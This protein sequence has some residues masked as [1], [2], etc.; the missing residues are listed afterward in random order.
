MLSRVDP[1]QTKKLPLK[2]DGCIFFQRTVFGGRGIPPNRTGSAA[3]LKL[4]RGL[5]PREFH[6]YHEV[7]RSYLLG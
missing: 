2:C 5:T 6:G 1:I 3:A 7:K 4:M